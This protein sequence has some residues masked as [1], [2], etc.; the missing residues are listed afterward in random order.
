MSP[1]LKVSLGPNVDDL[2][3]IT[4][5]DNSAHAVR[6]RL[7]DG[8]VSVNIK[9]DSGVTKSSRDTYFDDESRATC[10]WSIRIQGPHA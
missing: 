7:F 8:L 3:E 10:T 2:N 5:N 1:V 6:S 4:Y 9:G